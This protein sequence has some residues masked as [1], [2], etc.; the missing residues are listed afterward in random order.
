YPLRMRNLIRKGL[1]VPSLWIAALLLLGASSVRADAIGAELILLTTH[2]QQQR[3]ADIARYARRLDD[4]GRNVLTPGIEVSYEWN[5]RQPWLLAKQNRV[6]LGLLS[7]SAERRFGYI[8]YLARWEPYTSDTWGVSMQAGPGFIWRE[9]WR[10]FPE[11][12]ANNSLRQSKSFLPGYEWALLPLGEVDLL[13]AWSS[14]S[15]L[16][17]SVFPGIPYVVTQSFGFRWEF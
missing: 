7:D 13:Y 16:V 3:D 12:R 10:V 11:Y 6:T 9:T 2:L 5:L 17:W 15:K 14:S 1:L 8:A 4:E